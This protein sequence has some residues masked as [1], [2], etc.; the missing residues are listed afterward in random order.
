MACVEM[1][2]LEEGIGCD[3]GQ[4]LN[5]KKVIGAL[6]SYMYLSCL[7]F[8]CLATN[9][10]VSTTLNAIPK[11]KAELTAMNCRTVAEIS[12]IVRQQKLSNIFRNIGIRTSKVRHQ[13]P[14]YRRTSHSAERDAY[15]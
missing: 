9:M 8:G 4:M 3:A 15:N 12:V 2:A 1:N 11:L 10:T 5:E 6:L 7:I 14:A 13:K